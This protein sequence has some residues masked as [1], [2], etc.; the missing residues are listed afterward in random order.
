MPDAAALG[1]MW[2]APGKLRADVMR[3]KRSRIGI[4]LVRLLAT[5]G[6]RIFSTERARELGPRVGI[7]EAYLWESLYHLRR[8]GWIVSLR[9][10]L[11][12]LS[13]TVPGLT[14]AHEFEIAMALVDPAAISHWSALHH[15]GLTEQAPRRVFVLTTSGGVPRMRGAK[16]KEDRQGFPVGDTTYLRWFRWTSSTWATSWSRGAS[17]LRSARPVEMPSY[18]VLQATVVGQRVLFERA[19]LE[20]LESRVSEVAWPAPGKLAADVVR[21]PRSLGLFA[22]RKVSQAVSALAPARW[23]NRYFYVGARR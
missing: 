8:N 10:G 15:H 6:D 9:R 17:E 22:L 3:L 21:R 12:A 13:S 19:G 4:E 20:P 14:P 7:K 16:A 11:Y 5:E 23:G 2:P 1:R 18:H